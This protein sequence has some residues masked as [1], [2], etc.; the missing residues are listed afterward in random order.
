ML[1]VEHVLVRVIRVDA[2]E[3]DVGDGLDS[4]FVG[5]PERVGTVRDV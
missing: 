3:M 2:H 4:V 5:Q 1:E